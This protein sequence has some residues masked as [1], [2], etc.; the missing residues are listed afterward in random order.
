MK[1]IR[2]L[3]IIV[4]ILS[5]GAYAFFQVKHSRIDD[6]IAPRIS[7]DTDAVEVSVKDDE[8]KIL[9]GVTASDSNDGDVSDTLIVESMGQFLSPGRRN[10]TIAAV[11]GSGNVAKVT[12]QVT[13]VDYT[14]PKFELSEALRF[15]INTANIIEN[16]TATDCLDGDLTRQIKVSTSNYLDTTVADD[17][18]VT[19]TV[20]NSAG[21]ISKLPCTVTIY[22]NATESGCPQFELSEY[23]IYVKAGTNVNPWNY[24]SAISM[25]GMHYE[26]REDGNLYSQD[27][28]S[29]I[30]QAEVSIKGDVDLNTPGTYEYNYKI[31]DDN[32]RTGRVRLIVVVE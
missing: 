3:S 25:R 12:R 29:S 13:Y 8:E 28:S 31:T 24:V 5:F 30:T 11:D 9:E 21:D 27:G 19:F 2:I 18:E 4:F 17:Y 15:P 32:N 14:A 6:R 20:T 10:V 7:M 1:K 22:D 26:R 16:L 23:L